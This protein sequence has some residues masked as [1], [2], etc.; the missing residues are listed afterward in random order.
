MQEAASL[1]CRHLP[2]K[3]LRISTWNTRGLLGSAT[4]SHRP[5][6]RKLRHLQKNVEKSDILCLQETHGAIEHL[7]NI[8]V[9]LDRALWMKCGTFT[10]GNVNSGGSVILARNGISGP[11]TT[12][13]HEE[14]FPGRD[15]LIRI[16]QLDCCCTVINLHYQPEGTLQELHRRFRGASARWPAY[17]DGEGFLVGDF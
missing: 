1:T 13:E 7:A 14:I 3:G 16:R 8:D 2:A 15:H 9:F 4:Q 6:E 5:R 17:P 12:I 10:P 11:N